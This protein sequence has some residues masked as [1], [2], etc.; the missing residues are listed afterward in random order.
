MLRSVGL[1]CKVKWFIHHLE[2]HIYFNYY[3]FEKFARSNGCVS[4]TND[5]KLW[6]Q[7]DKYVD[8]EKNDV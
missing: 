7:M 8:F 4:C 6:T 1:N 2:V 3:F 5:P